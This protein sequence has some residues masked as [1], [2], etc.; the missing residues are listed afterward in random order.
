MFITFEGPEG[1]GK[2]SAVAW[3]ASWLG[4]RG[5]PVVTARE[6]GG[7]PIGEHIRSLLLHPPAPIAA[8]TSLLLFNAARAELVRGVLRP[9]LAA[10]QIVLCDRFADSTLAYQGYGEGLPLADVRAANELGS[11]GLVPDFTILL[12][13]AAEVGLR[14]RRREGEWNAMDDRAVEFHRA[15]RDGF[16][17]LAAAEPHRWLIVDAALPVEAVRAVIASRVERLL[18]AVAPGAVASDAGRV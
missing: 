3:L 18:G 12:D 10:G 6:P 16:L 4:A 15:V 17:Q 13:V 8:A 11:Q 5:I 2:S 1:S 14:R 9:A 7:T